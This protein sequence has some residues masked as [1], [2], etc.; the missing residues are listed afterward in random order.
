MK[1]L[2][3]IYLAFFVLIVSIC[4]FCYAL[5]CHSLGPVS[6]DDTLKVVEIEPGSISSIANTLYKEKLIRNKFVFKLY[7]KLS[8]KSNL[9]AATYELSRD[10][11]TRKIV[12]ILHEGKGSNSNQLKI[13]FKEGFNVMKFAKIM[14]NETNHTE[15]EVYSLMEDKE[16]L[17]SLIEKYWFLTDDILNDDIYYSLEGYLYPNTYY[18]SSKDV[19][20]KEVID[21][22]LKETDK[23]FLNYREK[24][25]ASSMSIHKI[26]TMA[27]MVELEGITEE[28]RKGIARVFFNRMDANMNLGSDVT[29]YYAAKINMGDRDL[30]K[31]ELQ[32]CNH[33]NTRCANFV[34]LPASP[35]CNPIA[36][37]V[38]AVL[39]PEDNDAYYFVA[40]KNKKV[41]F[42]RTI[43]EHNNTISRLKRNDLWY[44]Y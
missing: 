16:Y 6:D 15:E 39:E 19:D 41:Y 26:L 3:N 24:M 35:I 11:G 20:L 22:M 30:T 13:T 10:M 31:E 1:I 32:E 5:F 8:G 28:D 29:T 34:E 25:E 37:S 7:V 43:N 44:E 18:F 14:S 33:Y 4:V 2:H 42:S 12:D 40:D 9:K 38:L 17:N 21:T 27:S 36:Q 23:Q